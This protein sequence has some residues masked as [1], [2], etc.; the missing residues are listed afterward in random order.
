MWMSLCFSRQEL[1]SIIN[2]CHPIQHQLS[3][4]TTTKSNLWRKVF[5]LNKRSILGCFTSYACL[6]GQQNYPSFMW[7]W[8]FDL[9]HALSKC[10]STRSLHC[11]VPSTC[12]IILSISRP[13]LVCIFCILPKKANKV[14]ATNIMHPAIYRARSAK[15]RSPGLASLFLLLLT[16]S[17]CLWQLHSRNLGTT[18]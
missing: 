5:E 2:Y 4:T 12:D 11:Q 18:F 6:E 1:H 7:I 14:T 15:R 13:H 8:P 10:Q 17:F 16:A 3:T 9:P